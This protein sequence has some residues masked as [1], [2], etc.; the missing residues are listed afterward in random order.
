VTLATLHWLTAPWASGIDRRA[1]L[2]VALLGLAG[3][4][5][6]CWLVFFQL[7][8][9]A[10]SLAHALLPG[11]V[12]AALWGVPL[13]VGGAVGLIVAALATAIAAR[14]KGIGSD[15]AT[16]VVITTLFGLGALLAL[17]PATPPGLDGL[18][19]GDVLGVST[20]DL[21]LAGALVAVLGI[22][23]WVL[24]PRLLV[25]GFDRGAAS[26]L[27]VRPGAIDALLLVLLAVALLV[28]VQGLGNLL[29]VAVLIAPASAARLVHRRMG[30]MMLTSAAIAVLAGVVGIYVSYHARVAAGAAVALALVAAYAVAS[31]VSLLGRAGTARSTR[32]A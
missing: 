4:T 3:G 16:A 31:L 17:T 5:L 32:A 22:A 14:I 29:V 15:T 7:S 9:G 11:L 10:E 25:V 12:L 26:G 28:A 20:S 13:L 23:L 6:G 19:F 27:G 18:L 21:I 2:E 8:Y 30:P 1:L 24:H